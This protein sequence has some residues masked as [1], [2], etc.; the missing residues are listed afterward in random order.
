MGELLLA[1]ARPAGGSIAAVTGV[2]LGAFGIGGPALR[3]RRARRSC[4]C[5]AC[6]ACA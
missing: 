2:V 4:A 6:A 1:T 5:S 3:V